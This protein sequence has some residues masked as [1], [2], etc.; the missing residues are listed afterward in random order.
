MPSGPKRA[1]EWAQCHR[2]VLVFSYE[3]MRAACSLGCLLVE[4]AVPNEKKPRRRKT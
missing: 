3:Q 1:K 2:T 4:A